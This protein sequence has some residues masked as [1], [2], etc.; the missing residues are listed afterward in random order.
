LHTLIKI[1][2]FKWNWSNS[3]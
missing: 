3:Y 2:W 1:N